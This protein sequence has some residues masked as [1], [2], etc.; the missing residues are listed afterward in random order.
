MK[1]TKVNLIQK[2][3]ENKYQVV[4]KKKQQIINKVFYFGK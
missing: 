3:L 4:L 2:P 1:A